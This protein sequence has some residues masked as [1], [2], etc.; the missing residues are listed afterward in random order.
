MAHIKYQV[1][2]LE[3]DFILHAGDRR[4]LII[5]VYDED[6]DNPGDPDLTSPINL[7]SAA[8]RFALATLLSDAAPIFVKTKLDG[9]ITVGGDPDFNEMEIQ[10]EIADTLDL[11]GKFEYEAEVD[12]SGADNSTVA[13]GRITITPTVLD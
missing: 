3:N 11:S 13:T 2:R 12:Q 10:L 7:Q 6:P 5:E 8:L 4:V 9:E 1:A